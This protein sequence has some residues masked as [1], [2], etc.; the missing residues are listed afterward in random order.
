M[1]EPRAANQRIRAKLTSATLPPANV[2]RVI[3]IRGRSD[4][5]DACDTTISTVDL[6]GVVSCVG[7]KAPLRMH[8]GCLAIWQYLSSPRSRSRPVPLRI[9]RSVPAKGE[10]AEEEDSMTCAYCRCPIKHAGAKTVGDT[11]YHAGCW[12][13][14]LRETRR[15][16]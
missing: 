11:V 6:M 1:P 3:V 10:G 14:K 7:S 9:V 2:R 16:G 4:V 5:C 15:P 13:R 12:D 8:A